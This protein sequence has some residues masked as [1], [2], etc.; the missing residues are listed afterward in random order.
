MRCGG[1]V[2]AEPP[3]TSQPDAN[4]SAGVGS[5]FVRSV[6]GLRSDFLQIL[7]GGKAVVLSE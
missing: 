4:M 5:V 7:D 3:L 6:F 1:F 2:I